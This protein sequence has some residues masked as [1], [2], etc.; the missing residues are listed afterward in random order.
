[1][2][3][4]SVMMGRMIVNDEIASRNTPKVLYIES[5]E[6]PCPEMLFGLSSEPKNSE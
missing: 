5:G 3:V 4:M 2:T 1:M 6:A